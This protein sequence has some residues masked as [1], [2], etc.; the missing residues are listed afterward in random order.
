MTTIS[1]TAIGGLYKATERFARDTRT[2]VNAPVTGSDTTAALVD[3]KQSVIAYRANAAVIR[4]DNERTQ[5]L[6]DITA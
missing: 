2:V 4:L 6:L 3:A 5:S 1:Q